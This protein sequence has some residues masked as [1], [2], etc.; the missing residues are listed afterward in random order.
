MPV[1]YNAYD[2]F[3]AMRDK[4]SNIKNDFLCQCVIIVFKYTKEEQPYVN[5]HGK[6][7]FGDLFCYSEY[8]LG[9]F[10]FSNHTG[11]P[12]EYG[13]YNLRHSFKIRSQTEQLHSQV[14]RWISSSSSEQRNLPDRYDT[15]LFCYPPFTGHEVGWGAQIFNRHR[16]QPPQHQ[17]TCGPLNDVCTL[18]YQMALHAPG[19]ILT[20]PGRNLRHLLA[21]DP[22]DVPSTLVGRVQ[23]WSHE[24]DVSFQVAWTET[25][26][27]SFDKFVIT[28]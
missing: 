16:L 15:I 21:Q 24:W 22:P 27:L 7:V 6:F 11:I 9:P 19:S 13:D 23:P 4:V 5:E 3:S 26:K 17:P 25:A 28:S 12:L 10:E 2:V 18:P 20:N 8:S 1:F 14:S